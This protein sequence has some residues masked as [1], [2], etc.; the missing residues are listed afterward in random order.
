MASENVTPARLE[1]ATEVLDRA[2]ELGLSL[3][4]R[5]VLEMLVHT[6]DEVTTSDMQ[7]VGLSD[8]ASAVRDLNDKGI[9]MTKRMIRV[10]TE[11]GVRSFAS[12]WVLTAEEAGASDQLDGRVNI[13]VTFRRAL[14][15]AW[16]YR[17]AMCMTVFPS[18][19]LQPDHRVPFRVAGD[20]QVHDIADFMPLC[21]SHNRQKSF[22]CE[23]C[24]NYVVGDVDT[25]R[26]C[27]WASPESYT[28]VATVEQRQLDL[29][30]RG[31]ET[32]V[33]DA[34]MEQ[35]DAAG[36]TVQDVVRQVLSGE[37]DI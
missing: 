6:G 31:D 3:R 14:Y 24:P 37:R 13:P 36:L 33:F 16:G 9:R 8:P 7:A 28:H 11:N 2:S 30:F 23:R 27:Y 29:T 12:Y 26:S 35:A 25:C 22:D 5:K 32:D 4:A 17:C 19:Q 10:R 34:L 15:E 18:R 1:Y 21:G 20:V